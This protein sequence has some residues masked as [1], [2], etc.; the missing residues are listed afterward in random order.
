[1]TEPKAFWRL[2]FGAVPASPSPAALADETW[3]RLGRS[4]DGQLMA[5][6]PVG[7]FLSGGIDSSCVA[8]LARQKA[9][10]SLKTFSIA[11]EDPTFDESSYARIVAR[12]IGSEHV[13]ERLGEHN[14][15][16]V[17]DLALEAGRAARRSSSCRPSSSRASPRAT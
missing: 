13:E 10:R 9:G 5:D 7:V 11:F 17:V 12:Q 8:V 15:L 3:S 1:M 16:E 4:V 2:A 14:V 6:V